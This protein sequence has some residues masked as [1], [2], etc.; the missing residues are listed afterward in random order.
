MQNNALCYQNAVKLLLI[1]NVTYTNLAFIDIT[2][3][4]VFH[5]K[6][7]VSYDIILVAYLKE[8]DYNNVVSDMIQMYCIRVQ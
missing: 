2:T 7:T 1:A 3:C 5:I 6:W 4:R 8:V